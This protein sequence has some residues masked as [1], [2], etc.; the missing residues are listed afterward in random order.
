MTEQEQRAAIVAEARSFEGTLYHHKGT[1]KIK[2][3][4]DGGVIDRGGVDCA[5]FPFLV[6]SA[7]GLIPPQTPETMESYPPDWYLHRDEERYLKTVETFARRV[8]VPGPGDFVLWKVGRLFAHGAIVIDWP[9]IIHA[10]RMVGQVTLDQGNGG[11]LGDKEH[12]FFS[13]WGR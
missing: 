9:L 8:D 2:R 12:L 1:L 4:A 5:W 10:H 7:V 6:Y 3:D 11:W 13:V